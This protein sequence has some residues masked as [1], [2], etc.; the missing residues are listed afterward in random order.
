MNGSCKG[1]SSGKGAVGSNA[2]GVAAAGGEAGRAAARLSCDSD[3]GRLL[4]QVAATGFEFLISPDVARKLWK[5][6][7]KLKTEE[8][9]NPG[10]WIYN[11]SSISE[12]DEHTI[13]QFKGFIEVGSTP[14]FH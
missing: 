2:G 7:I 14:L 5:C 13:S 6:Q 10:S 4:G 12:T 11:P 9:Y 3:D 1:S 8:Q